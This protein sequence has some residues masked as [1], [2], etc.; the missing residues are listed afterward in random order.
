MKNEVRDRCYQKSVPV[1]E[2]T[3]SG[4]PLVLGNGKIP[5]VAAIDRQ[6][7]GKATVRMKVGSF[8]FLVSA[9]KA[10]EEI[11][12]NVGDKIFLKEG[13]LS[14]NEGDLYGYA[15]EAIAAGKEAEIEVQLA[16]K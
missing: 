12:I 6:A 9:K 15:M 2:G 8:K 14:L 16:T 13:K 7:N 10:A 4:D 3:K 1:P 11:A 5:A